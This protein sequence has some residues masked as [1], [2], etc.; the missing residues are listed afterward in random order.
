[1]KNNRL[2]PGL[3]ANHLRVVLL[4]AGIG[5]ISPDVDG[6]NVYTGFYTFG[7]SLTDSGNV[8][9]ATGGVQ[10]YPS[11]RFSD[12][13]TWA[14]QL[15]TDYMGFPGHSASLVGG[16]NHAW[17]G[18]LISAAGEVPSVAD[19]VNG[20]VAGG[21]TFLTTDLVALWAGANDFFAPL[22]VGGAPPDPAVTAAGLSGLISTLAGAGAMNVLVLNLPNLGDT[23]ALR[24]A[25]ALATPWTQSFN[26][27]LAAGAEAQGSTLGINLFQTDIYSLSGDVIGTPEKFGLTN[28]TGAVFPDF[29][30][31]PA[32]TAYWD[33]VHPTTVVH[34]IFAR[35]VAIDVGII[36]EPSAAV[37]VFTVAV[38]FGTRRRRTLV[39]TTLE[40]RPTMKRILKP[41]AVGGVIIP[42]VAGLTNCQS[43]GAN[44]DLVARDARL[45]TRPVEELGERI[46]GLEIV[47]VNGER[48]GRRSSAIHEG[49]NQIKTK[50]TWPQGG[51]QE[52]D[53]TFEARK[54][55]SYFV[56]FK[57]FPPTREVWGGGLAAEDW[58]EMGSA[59]P[60]GPVVCVAP[61]IVWAVWER[62]YRAA[63]VVSPPPANYTD[64]FVISRDWA[65]GVVG[66]V[67]AYEDGRIDSTTWRSERPSTGRRPSPADGTRRSGILL[68]PPLALDPR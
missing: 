24:A 21:G 15:A 30:L 43:S 52:V 13:P 40:P 8:A 18:A 44:M 10:P 35:Q 25:A 56:K 54:G 53:L 39:S 20:F 47:S 23:P 31:D 55:K 49:L 46:K 3:V 63:Q 11:G 9:V 38:F 29:V 2:I 51:T 14:E 45:E 67:R 27:A 37:Y 60:Y 7:D 62:L 64:V 34:G 59:D 19:Q 41:L 68:E 22:E 61:V 48:T 33:S 57:G 16:S 28:S 17:G 6:A 58:M 12:G 66:R 5:F 36:P 26:V 50:F 1:M 32:K 42:I 65:E 4:G